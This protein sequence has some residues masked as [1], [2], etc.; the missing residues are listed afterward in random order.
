MLDFG[1]T[2]IRSAVLP[3]QMWLIIYACHRVSSRRSCCR[4]SIYEIWHHQRDTARL[5]QLSSCVNAPCSDYLDLPGTSKTGQCTRRCYSAHLH[6]DLPGTS[7]TGQ[8]IRRC[9]ST[10][11][12]QDRYIC[13]KSLMNTA[14]KEIGW[15]CLSLLSKTHHT[16]AECYSIKP[17][18]GICGT[19]WCMCC[20]S[21]SPTWLFVGK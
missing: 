21:T 17:G 16:H 13:F 11:L 20:F 8:C 2:D 19:C 6:L 1:R 10:Q 7:K 9:Y 3:A 15:L 14:W 12:T 18:A 4:M 5:H